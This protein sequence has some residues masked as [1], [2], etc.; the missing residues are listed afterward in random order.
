MT[1]RDCT[2]VDGGAASRGRAAGLLPALGPGF[3]P[4]TTKKALLN[5]GAQLENLG[6]TLQL[7]AWKKSTNCSELSYGMHAHTNTVKDM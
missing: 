3:I 1:Q 7:T 6:P 4:Y 2:G 5:H